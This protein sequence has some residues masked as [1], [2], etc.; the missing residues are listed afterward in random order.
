MFRCYIHSLR[1]GN[2]VRGTKVV[3]GDDEC[4]SEIRGDADK[5]LARPGRR[6]A[7]ET[8]LG[9]YSTHS[10][11]RSIHFLARC[12]NFC[13][14]HPNSCPRQ[15]WPPL[16]TKNADLR[17]W[18]LQEVEDPKFQDNLYMMVVRL[19]VLH[20]GPLYSQEIFLIRISV[21]SWVN[22]RATVRPVRLC[23]WKISIT[24][25]RIEAATFWLVAQCINHLL[26]RVVQQ[27]NIWEK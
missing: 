24:P 8:T 26:H 14:S 9:I 4:N 20:S 16:W 3:S 11:R 19:S 23:Q 18:G 15:Q 25:S 10:P 27:W 6:Q 2:S 5:S 7:T 21:K 13:K 1:Q 12:F 22:P 17:P